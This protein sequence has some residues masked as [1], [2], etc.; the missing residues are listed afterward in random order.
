MKMPNKPPAPNPATALR[1]HLKRHRRRVG[2]AGRSAMG[3]RV[4]TSTGLALTILVSGCRSTHPTA[5]VAGADPSTVRA[6]SPTAGRAVPPDLPTFGAPVA[7]SI[8]VAVFG[9][10][11]TVRR[12]GFYHLPRGAVVREAVEAAQ[13]L[14]DFTW[15]RTYSG[16]ERI[17]PGGGLELIRFTRDRA[18]EEQI[19]LQ[20]GDKI[21]F[22]HEVY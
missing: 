10:T 2:E 6:A 3:T 22:G 4:I 18:R 11:H 8:R 12:P 19:V 17:K 7:D 13:G 16:I 15:W 14:S 21:Y 9:M 1:F 5:D 20:D